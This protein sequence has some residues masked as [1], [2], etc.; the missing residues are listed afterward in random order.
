MN[1]CLLTPEHVWNAAGV[2]VLDGVDSELEGWNEGVHGD[3]TLGLGWRL[4]PCPAHDIILSSTQHD[5]YW[6]QYDKC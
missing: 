3:K 6:T 2:L 4:S 1:Q 5:K